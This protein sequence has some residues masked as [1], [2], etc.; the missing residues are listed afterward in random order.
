M[1]P[2][3]AKV[4]ACNTKLASRE[5]ELE[6][7]LLFT[8]ECSA[9]IDTG[10]ATS[11]CVAPLNRYREQALAYYEEC[12]KAVLS[13]E[14]A[15]TAYED[16]VDHCQRL[17]SIRSAV[18]KEV[19]SA[20]SAFREQQKQLQRE[21]A[22]QA[23]QAAALAPAAPQVAGGQTK[24]AEEYLRPQT[25]TETHAPL[26]F[27]TWK[28]KFKSWF[29]SGGFAA[30]PI[31]DQR[32]RLEACMSDR[33]AQQLKAI[34]PRDTTMDACIEFISKEL[35]RR[36]PLRTRQIEYFSLQ[37]KINPDAEYMEYAR[38]LEAHAK[39]QLITG[40]SSARLSPSLQLVVIFINDISFLHIFL[41]IQACFQ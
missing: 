37:K 40:L 3:A 34:A 12:K 19:S 31:P 21:E 4:T 8:R 27:E 22:E 38:L 18:Y 29:S 30:L 15:G 14:G 39:T 20:Q 28:M 1:A 13:I 33:M 36:Y 25:L 32:C 35:E 6:E 41:E 26:E 17:R 2:T 11:E 16:A 10:T 24:K 23:A 9:L 7:C 5:K